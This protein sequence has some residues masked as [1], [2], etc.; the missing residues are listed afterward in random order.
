[1][2]TYEVVLSPSTANRVV[3]RSQMY[4]VWEISTSRWGW[5]RRKFLFFTWAETLEQAEKIAR[6]R[7]TPRRFTMGE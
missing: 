6:I 3:L 7:L 4:D 1:M 2:K 5:E